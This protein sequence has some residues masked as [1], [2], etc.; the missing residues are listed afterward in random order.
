MPALALVLVL[1]GI[2][3]GHPLRRIGVHADWTRTIGQ[4]GWT[5]STIWTAWA[6]CQGIGQPPRLRGTV[7]C[8]RIDGTPVNPF[9]HAPR[10]VEERAG[11]GL[12]NDRVQQ[13]GAW[14]I[15]IERLLPL[16]IDAQ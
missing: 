11:S 12:P 15:E 1:H 6:R 8:V 9:R 14:Q 13:G 3:S 5:A 16:L 4:P 2:S 10:F 7:T